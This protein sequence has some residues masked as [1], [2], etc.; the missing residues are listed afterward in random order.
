M[1][2]LLLTT[3]FVRLSFGLHFSNVLGDNMV[4]Q[5]SPQQAVVWGFSSPFD[6]VTVNFNGFKDYTAADLNGQFRMV[7]P[8]MEEGGPVDVLA[9]STITGDQALLRN[10][11]FGDVFFCSGQSNMEFTLGSGFNASEEI[12]RANLYPN[13]RLMTV[14]QRTASPT[15]LTELQTIEQEWSIA[16]NESVGGEDWT[17]FSAVC[18]LFGR[19]IHDYLKGAVPI[20]LIST[21]W[22]GTPV[23]DWCSSDALAK[24]NQTKCKHATCN[25]VGADE[26]NSALYNSMIAPFLPMR[27]LGAIWYQGEENV[28]T[29]PQFGEDYY[30][31]QFPAMIEDWRD[32]FDLKDMYFGFVQLAAYKENGGTPVAALRSGQ[33]AALELPMVGMASAVDLGDL[34]SPLGSIHPRNKQTVAR[35]LAATAKAL[36]YKEILVHQGPM[37]AGA[38]AANSSKISGSIDETSVLISFD[39]DTLGSGLIMKKVCCPEDLDYKYCSGFQLQTADQ[40][41]HNAMAMVYG[42]TVVVS[43]AM[44]EDQRVLGVRYGYGDWP[45][46][47]IFNK[48]GFPAI[49]FTYTL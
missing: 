39:P 24:C 47:T 35:R 2:F 5:R 34:Y 33:L 49:P 43:S 26:G 6:V 21:N 17:Y 18:W 45:V 48:E 46:M 29:G 44:V 27:A 32:K 8:P 31:C 13:I 12:A 22:H 15:P 7:L 42:D 37:F 40:S 28:G 11:M 9:M 1:L 3:I 25:G 36:I 4:L 38:F 10:V 41:W 20:G 19:D 30:A 14:G 16:S 23:Q